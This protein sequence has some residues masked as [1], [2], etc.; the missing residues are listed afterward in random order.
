M[1]SVTYM[2]VPLCLLAPHREA[3]AN[4]REAQNGQ[5]VRLDGRA[6]LAEYQAKVQAAHKAH[7][8][9]GASVNRKSQ[10]R[11][12]QLPSRHAEPVGE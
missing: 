12:Y 3:Q 6:L 10:W 2:F 9:V 8:V 4:V 1:P 7:V 11:S 5:Q